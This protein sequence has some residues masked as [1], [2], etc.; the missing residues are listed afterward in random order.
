MAVDGSTRDGIFKEVF[1]DKLEETVPD[2]SIMLQDF[3]FNQRAKLGETYL[4]PVRFRRGHGVTF[5]SGSDSL[6]AFS[7]NAVKS[8]QTKQASVSGSTLVGRES[9]AYKTVAAA[10][11]NGKQAFVDAFKDGVE[12]L[13]N[14]AAFYLEAFQRY[15]QTSFGAFAADG[16]NN[17]TQDIALTAASSAPGLWAQMEGAYVDIYSDTTFGTK[18]NASNTVE[19]TG[20]DFDPSTGQVTLS[21]SG[22]ASELDAVVAGDVVVP[23]GFYSSGHKT[24]AGLDKILTNTGSLFGIDASTYPAWAGSTYSVGSAAATFAKIIRACVAIA[25]RCPPMSEALVAYVSPMTWADLNNNA[26]ALR[27]Y[28]ESQKGSVD[29]GTGKITYYSMAGQRIEIKADP[30]MK[31]GEA[32][33]L[34][35]SLVERGGVTEPTF[36]LQGETGQNPRFLLELSGSAGFEIRIMWDQ[37][38]IMRKPRGGVKLT[39]IVN[40]T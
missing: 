6:T 37:F 7:L 15:G 33:I 14:T 2:W 38:T 10:T 12:D 4:F 21:L 27:R 31:G 23:R 17:A 20:I 9:F 40:N 16:T 29:L 39:N 35:P 8:G 1:G 25:V 24:L 32:M 3:K 19:V 11:A 28:T 5:E 18:R 22:N 26:A 13:Y 30:M 34:F 36:K